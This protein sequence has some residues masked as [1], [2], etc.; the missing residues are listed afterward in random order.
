MPVSQFDFLLMMLRYHLN[1]VS[2]RFFLNHFSKYSYQIP[3][4]MLRQI[5]LNEMSSLRQSMSRELKSNVTFI[6]QTLRV[7][8]FDI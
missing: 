5:L 3:Y 7:E 1:D 8:L 2:N 4:N 6:S